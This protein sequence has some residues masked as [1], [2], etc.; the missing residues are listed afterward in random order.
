[1]TRT[2]LFPVLALLAMSGGSTLAAEAESSESGILIT[3]QPTG[4]ANTAFVPLRRCGAEAAVALQLGTVRIDVPPAALHHVVFAQGSGKRNPVERAFPEDAGCAESPLAV[5]SALLTSPMVIALLDPAVALES[6]D[7]AVREAA[8]GGSCGESDGLRRC[9]AT[10]DGRTNLSLT[11]A[12]PEAPIE[13]LCAGREGAE[14]QCRIVGH[15][16]NG[17]AYGVPI[18]DGLVNE[19]SLAVILAQARTVMRGLLRPAAAKPDAL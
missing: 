11:L 8:A 15:A 16:P 12:D 13:A 3:V 14:P 19:R 18:A 2:L 6:S 4:A 5:R 9:T 10:A 17:P 7:R 1:M